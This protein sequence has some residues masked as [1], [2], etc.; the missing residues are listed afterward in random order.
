MSSTELL[1]KEI[2]KLPASY[3][4][5]I[6]DFVGYLRAAEAKKQSAG[7]ADPSKRVGFLKG[8]EVPSDFDT[9]GQAAIAAL[10]EG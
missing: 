5:E 6:L 9:M 4:G 10:F 3:M 8:I 2:E 7:R 1:I